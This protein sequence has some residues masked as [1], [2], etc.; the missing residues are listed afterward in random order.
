MQTG[1]DGIQACARCHFHAGADPTGVR[2]RNQFPGTS[3]GGHVPLSERRPELFAE[4]LDYP[5]FQVN[6]VDASRT[7]TI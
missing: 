6:P 2:S 7:G 1:S 5:F 3:A 4:Q